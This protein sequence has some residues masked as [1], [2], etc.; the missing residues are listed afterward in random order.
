[1]AEYIYRGLE[2]LKPIT[3]DNTPVKLLCYNI[4][5]LGKFPFIQFLLMS[6]GVNPF[7]NNGIENLF[8]PILNNYNEEYILKLVSIYVSHIAHEVTSDIT[9][10][11]CYEYN[12]IRYIF[13]DISKINIECIF[14]NKYSEIWMALPSEIINNRHI[15]NIPIEDELRNLFLNNPKLYT[16]SNISK[17]NY[18]IPDIVYSGSHFKA[19]EFQG[20]FAVSKKEGKY[21]KYYYFNSSLQTAFRE[22]G[23]SKDFLPEYKYEEL[24]TDNEYGRY[25]CGGINRIALLLED[26]CVTDGNTSYECDSFIICS[27]GEPVILVKDY[28]QQI[29]LSYHKIHKK[30]LGEQWNENAH[31]SIE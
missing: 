26:I 5:S 27:T 29:G 1:M 7:F 17:K 3:H 18:P 22:G 4:N 2:L 15:C 11:G 9:I 13:I 8:C 24:I 31:Y 19:T 30:T 6:S 25:I 28:N 21:G 20:V 23:W 10:T 14:L 16:L 12:D